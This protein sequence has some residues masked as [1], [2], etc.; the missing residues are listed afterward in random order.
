MHWIAM[1]FLN[2]AEQALYKQILSFEHN[3]YISEID[4]IS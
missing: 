3:S 4:L 2:T 1:A